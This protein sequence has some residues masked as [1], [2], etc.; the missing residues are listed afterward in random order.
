MADV[1]K[2]CLFGV[3]LS[4]H[5][6]RFFQ[7]EVGDVRLALKGV[8]RQIFYTAKFIQRFIR[9]KIRIGNVGKGADAETKHWQLQVQN[10]QRNNFKAPEGKG[11]GRDWEEG[12]TRQPRVIIRTENVGKIGLDLSQ[13]FAHPIHG[14]VD[15][16]LE[17]VG[18]HIVKPGCVIAVG[19]CKQD[20]INMLN[21]FAQHLLPEI[22]A[23]VNY[24]ANVFC[25]NVY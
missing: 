14:H 13:R 7:V 15:V 1:C 18:A 23:G 9:N 16:L 19:V 25:L 4:R 6:D 20:R 17:I 5:S 8:E 10:R 3:D 21:V 2:P 12:E 22:R 11:C 24:Q